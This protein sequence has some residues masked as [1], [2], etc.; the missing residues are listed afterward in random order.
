MGSGRGI[1][2]VLDHG[3]MIER[4]D[5]TLMAFEWAERSAE[6][7]VDIFGCR[8]PNVGPLSGLDGIRRCDLT[9]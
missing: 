7:G 4:D 1:A 2:A 9:T 3:C 6:R 5:G 8:Q